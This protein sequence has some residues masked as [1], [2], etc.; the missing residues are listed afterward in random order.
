M[1]LML[2]AAGRKEW[3]EHWPVVV[4]AMAGVIASNVHI[5]STGVAI[6][7]LQKEFGW[8]RAEITSGFLIISLVQ[9]PLS[10]IMGILIDSFGP[11]LM[12]LSGVTLYCASIACLSLAQQAIWT[13]WLLWGLVA[14]GFSIIGPTVWIAAISRRFFASRGLAIAVMLGATG[15]VSLVCPLLMLILVK[16][17]GW[18]I[19][20]IILG[21]LAG[22]IALPPLYLFFSSANNERPSTDEVAVNLPGDDGPS[23]LV[24]LKSTFFWKLASAGPIMSAVFTALIVNFVPI[25][26]ANGMRA[27]TAAAISGVVGA[28]IFIGRLSGGALNDRF[29][30]RYV[31]GAIVLFPA[32]SCLILIVSDG[33]VPGVVLAVLIFGLSA[34][35][36]LDTLAYLASC[37]FDPRNF[38]AL[39]G[40]IIGFC[41]VGAGLGP[42]LAN[43]TY[44]HTGSY[45]SVLWTIIPLCLLSS[46]AFLTLGNYPE[47][48][49]TQ[50]AF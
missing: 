9:C 20:Y 40:I 42:V 23:F 27:A 45:G 22:G 10:F 4:A 21:G 35:A 7:P 39:F 6:A 31:G 18:R 41:S 37:Y 14:F 34:G 5:Y 17:F 49:K 13:W 44:D 26:T 3:R 43:W 28:A 46:Y 36:E 16:N 48:D 30:P 29:N 2:D 50:Q 25:L 33:Y 11:R 38:G 1:R 8:S 24:H 19:A 32:V 12:A 47:R 15:I